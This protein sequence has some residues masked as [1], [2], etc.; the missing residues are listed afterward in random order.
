[1]EITAAKI[2]SL[3]QILNGRAKQS[4][5]IRFSLTAYKYEDAKGTKLIEKA[6]VKSTRKIN[7]FLKKTIF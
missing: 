6:D 4:N 5:G 7:K 2:R 1:M 3:R